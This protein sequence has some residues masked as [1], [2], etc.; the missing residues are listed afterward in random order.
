MKLSTLNSLV[1]DF[2]DLPI[3]PSIASDSHRGEEENYLHEVKKTG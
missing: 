1:S 2:D 3:G